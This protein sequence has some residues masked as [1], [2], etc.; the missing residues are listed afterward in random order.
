MDI[1]PRAISKVCDNENKNCKG[2]KWRYEVKKEKTTIDN[3]LLPIKN[4]PNYLISSEGWVYSK[5][6]KSKMKGCKNR[7]D[8][9]YVTL[10]KER[11]KKN[12]FI[13]NLVATAFLDNPENK[14]YVIH[15]DKNKCNNHVD[16]LVWK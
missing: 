16:N 8:H 5:N 15:K 11:V 13:H 1:T 14:K 3:T 7:N 2:F 4:Y 6:T 12:K 10:C 9:E